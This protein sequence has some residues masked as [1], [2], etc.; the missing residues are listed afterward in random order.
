MPRVKKRMRGWHGDSEGHA[1]A[2]KKG[3]KT[4][5]SIY[6]KSFYVEM[7]RKGGKVSSGKF[8]EGSDRAREAGR[9]GGKKSRKKT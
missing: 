3:G 8:V 6:G 4:T 7:G 2:G 9:K 5:S 1:L